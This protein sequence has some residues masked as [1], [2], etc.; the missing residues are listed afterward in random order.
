MSTPARKQ[1][2][3]TTVMMHKSPSTKKRD[4]TR[5][6][7]FNL[8]KKE[9]AFE[10]KIEYLEQTLERKEN[11]ILKLELEISI[12]PLIRTHFSSD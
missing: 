10:E 9:D 3:A 2:A 1:D 5:M 7:Q 4:A 12:L 8:R 6:T 11:V